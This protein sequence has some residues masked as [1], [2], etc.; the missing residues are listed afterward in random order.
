VHT[1]SYGAENN[2]AGWLDG[3]AAIPRT[4]VAYTASVRENEGTC[5]AR[6]AQV[7]NFRLSPEMEGRVLGFGRRLIEW[8]ARVNLTGAQSVAEV[9]GEH[10]VDSFAMA[11][12][13]PP[14]SSVVDVGAGGGLPGIPFAILRPDARLVVV[15]PR[16]K[17]IAFLRTVV[18]ELQLA[19][20][21]VLRERADALDRGAFD[22]AA[23]RATFPPEEWLGIGLGLVRPGGLVLIFAG[24]AWAPDNS[25]LRAT[26]E[27]RYATAT[28]RSRWLGAFCST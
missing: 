12:L 8:N 23:S 28:G 1:L 14:G 11:S 16:A 5:L 9:M 22:V 19:S 20:T 18:R 27:I 2:S 17:R 24:D 7:W 21:E 15:E 3:L 6:L 13:V 10:V 26:N 4:E 25:S